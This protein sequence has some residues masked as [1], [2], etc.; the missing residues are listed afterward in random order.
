MFI[1]Y[2]YAYLRKNGTPYYIGKGKGYRA[3]SKNHAVGVPN[4]SRIIIL[5]KNLSEV[6]AL[7]LERRYILWYGRKDLGTGILYNRTDGGEAGI[8]TGCIPTP[9]AIANVRAGVTLAR[10]Q[11]R[12][13]GTAWWQDPEQRA[14]YL[15]SR[16]ENDKYRREN[17]LGRWSDTFRAAASERSKSNMTPER[18]KAMSNR[19]KDLN[20]K[21]PSQKGKRYWT[22]GV[23][24]KMSVHSPGPEWTLGYVR[25]SNRG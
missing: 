25:V 6:G 17:K 4:R 22:N 20:I 8:G 11:E 21:P 7:A 12:E 5:E 9:E 14:R 16:K 19:N 3:W 18:R 24:N 13:A 15:T 1:Y 2:V 23:K 10:Q